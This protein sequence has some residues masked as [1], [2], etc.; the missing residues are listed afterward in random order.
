MAGRYAITGVQLGMLI[1]LPSM[2]DRQQLAD[3]IEKYQYIGYSKNN[4]TDDVRDLTNA[5]DQ[6]IVIKVGCLEHRLTRTQF[7]TIRNLMAGNVTTPNIAKIDAIKYIRGE[8]PI[9][10]K[11]AKDLVESPE[12]VTDGRS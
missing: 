4:I 7:S 12:F 3:K 5:L 11:E 8:L 2:E 6:G 1:A 9:G 10:L